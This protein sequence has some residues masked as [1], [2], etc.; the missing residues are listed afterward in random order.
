MKGSATTAK[1][2]EE[3]GKVAPSAKRRLL[4][5]DETAE[6]LGISPATIRCGVGR[7]A[8]RKFP[9]KPVRIGSAVRFDLIDIEAFIAAQKAE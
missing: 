3:T 2:E 6:F 7:K 1:K 8:K 9:I 5:V 4:T